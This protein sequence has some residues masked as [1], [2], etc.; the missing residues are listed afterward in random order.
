ME[1]RLRKLLILIGIVVF[2]FT[3]ACS[4]DD[5]DDNS[6]TG[7]T[8]Q[9]TGD[10]PGA[11]GEGSGSGGGS[12]SIDG[13][14]A[15]GEGGGPLVLPA[16]FTFSLIANADTTAPLVI[17][18]AGSNPPRAVKIT[19]TN[20]QAITG[21]IIPA[22]EGTTSGQVTF[23]QGDVIT[24]TASN[25]WGESSRDLTIT[26]RQSITFPAGV[27]AAEEAL[28]SE[29]AF[30]VSYINRFN[31]TDTITVIF[32]SP[33][34]DSGV[35]VRMNEEQA[36]HMSPASFESLLNSTAPG[37]E[38]KADLSLIV[39]EELAKG[40]ALSAQTVS[41]AEADQDALESALT[42]PGGTGEVSFAGDQFTDARNPNS[43]VTGSRTLTWT[44][45]NADS[46]VDGG[47]SFQWNFVN[48][49]E[50]SGAMVND[51]TNGRVDLAS[52]IMNTTESDGQTVLTGTGFQVTDGSRPA[53]LFTDF[54]QSEVEE[55]SPGVFTTNANRIFIINGGFDIL[56]NG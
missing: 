42:A 9:T 6:T 13:Q 52:F 25:F 5:D 19:N 11:G 32:S 15:T 8:E 31:D 55:E 29:G 21:T 40:I 28:P 27:P 36:R 10:Q 1:I 3:L 50:S 14:P 20:G 56:F 30:N 12:G 39:F 53:V 41:T 38:Q 35:S 48:D 51:L 22:Q 45:V 4:D 17:S 47:D 2:A 43:P 37:W 49:W 7:S 44:D 23:S 46:L 54:Q 26:V 24:V 16:S 33:G 18:Q 34:A